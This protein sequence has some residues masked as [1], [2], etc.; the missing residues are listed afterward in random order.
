MQNLRTD[1]AKTLGAGYREVDRTK[2]ILHAWLA[3]QAK[4][5]LPYGTALNARYFQHDLKAAIASSTGFRKL[6]DLS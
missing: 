5:G 1:K 3:W 2:A 4:P 6:Y